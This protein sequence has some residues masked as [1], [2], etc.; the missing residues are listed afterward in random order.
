MVRLLILE[1]DDEL[2]ALYRRLLGP[3]YGVWL[4]SSRE[5]SRLWQLLAQGYRVP[6][7]GGFALIISSPWLEI[8]PDEPCSERLIRA[9]R[10]EFPEVPVIL[11]GRSPTAPIWVR[12]LTE[13]DARVH[14]LFPVT[15]H[16]LAD[17][18]DRLLGATVSS[19]GG[20]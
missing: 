2:R 5:A 16:A 3:R 11:A 4:W 8:N 20:I 18:V 17:L 7:V 19:E 6:E 10:R 15:E 12:L 13:V 9:L 14:G 1:D